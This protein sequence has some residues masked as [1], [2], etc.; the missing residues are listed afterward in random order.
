[1]NRSVGIG[2][3]LMMTLLCGCSRSSKDTCALVLSCPTPYYEEIARGFSEEME[4]MG[5]KA[6]IQ[7]PNEMSITEQYR[8]LQSLQKEDLAG[9]AIL[10]NSFSSL[11]DMTS[12]F[13]AEGIPVAA[14]DSGMNTEGIFLEIFALNYEET[15]GA[16][17]EYA[18]AY[19]EGEGQI[20]LLSTTNQEP[21]SESMIN[22]IRSI[23]ETGAYPGILLA[24]IAYGNNNA[25]RCRAKMEHLNDNYPDLDLVLCLSSE[26]TLS[27][28]AYITEMGLQDSLHVAGYGLPEEMDPY[29]GEAVPFYYTYDPEK[30]G[31]LTALVLEYAIRTEGPCKT[32]DR[33][34]FEDFGAF[35]VFGYSGLY[36]VEEGNKVYPGIIMENQ[37][38]W[39]GL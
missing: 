26:T 21:A 35:D 20:A 22:E 19:L 17:L 6:L 10:P 1:M 38:T 25:E 28:A 32:G 23:L 36:E 37:V 5:R 11:N 9:L 4:S 7:T 33:I 15:A 24:E 2:I 16:L 3:F 8:I 12:A 30:L 29:L 39:V 18:A 34:V 27:A 13:V 14:A 31:R